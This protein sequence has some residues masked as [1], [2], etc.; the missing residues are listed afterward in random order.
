MRKPVRHFD[1]KKGSSG[2]YHAPAS[3]EDEVG[4]EERK[5]E[6]IQ[7]LKKKKRKKIKI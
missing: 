2:E 4:E 3:T 6:K 7:I 1:L 5:T